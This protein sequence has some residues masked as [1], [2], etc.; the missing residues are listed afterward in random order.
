MGEYLLFGRNSVGSAPGAFRVAK[1]G[2]AVATLAEFRK[3]DKHE[4]VKRRQRSALHASETAIVALL[5]EPD[6]LGAGNFHNAFP[7]SMPTR[8][9][10]KNSRDISAEI[11]QF[12]IS[13][14]A[15]V[16]LESLELLTGAELV[17]AASAGWMP[18]Q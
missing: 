3:F 7:T 14:D 5:R 1:I 6:Q 16:E 2:G 17:G 15:V 18:T 10:L 8:E 11:G 4:A 13:Q 9:I 12:I